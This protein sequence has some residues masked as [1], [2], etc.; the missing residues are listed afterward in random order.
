[1]ASTNLYTLPKNAGSLSQRIADIREPSVWRYFTSMN[2]GDFETTVALFHRD[3]VLNPPFE[4]PITGREAI[5]IYLQVEA[6]GMQLYPR[7][8]VSHKLEDGK[9]EIFLTG[10][11]DTP[12]FGVN[13]SWQFF[14]DSQGE[15]TSVTVKLLAEPQE[16]L[17]LRSQLEFA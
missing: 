3:G 1:M 2:A 15:I 12:L 14:L 8:G 7:E 13:V 11:V 10:K 17:M 6:E 9:T 4:E 16:L 5:A